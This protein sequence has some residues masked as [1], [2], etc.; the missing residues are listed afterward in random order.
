MKFKRYLVILLM[1][2]WLLSM[3]PN[4][5]FIEEG[6]PK[7]THLSVLK[8]DYDAPK[9]KHHDTEGNLLVPY[10]IAYP[11]AFHNGTVTYDL[12]TIHIKVLSSHK[13]SPS[14]AM[15]AL[16]ILS[17]SKIIGDDYA[18][19]YEAVLDDD[20]DLHDVMKEVRKLDEVLTADYNYTIKKESLSSP[21]DDVT[22][23]NEVPAIFTTL[24]IENNPRSSEQWYLS[25][26]GIPEA[27]TWM[28]DNGF[29]PGGSED[30][31]VAVID[32]GVDYNHPDLKANMWVNPNEIEDG[33]DNDGNG[34]IDD[35]HG[36]SVISDS[37]FWSGDPMDD[38]GHGTHV[39]GI[40]AA[41]NNKEGIVG[42]AHNVKIMAV[43][44][45]MSSG[46]F[47]SSAIAKGI[48]YA[49]LNGADVINM[50]FG[51]S[52]PSIPVQDALMVAYTT[53]VL[54][55][56]A[57]NSGL[58]N[59]YCFPFP[60]Y[61]PN[62]PAAL[63]Y[64][65]GVM[66]VGQ[67]NMESG[68]S[69]WD[70]K[71]YNR[72]EYEVNAPGENILS[73]LPNG[74]YVSW[75]GTSMAAPVVSGIAAL[76]RSVY[77]DRDVYPNKFIM[78]QISA[79]TNSG[80][81][82]DPNRPLH[83]VP[84]VVNAFM[85][86]T[87]LPKPD[88]SLYDYYI[89]DSETISASNNGDGIIDAGETIH[90]GIV[91]RNRWGKSEN[92]VVTIDTVTPMGQSID[93]VGIL[94]GTINFGDVG[95]YS[96][97]DF[98]SREGS[99][100]TGVE[101]PHILTIPENAPNDYIAKI[102]VNFTYE[103]ALDPNDTTIYTG[104]TEI[105]ITIRNGF[106]LPNRITED[107]VLTKENY[108][109][110]PNS[111]L[112]EEGAT[113]TVQPGTQIQFWSDDPNDAYAETAMVYLQVKGNFIVEGT[114][115]E[116]VKLFP[117]QLRDQYRVEIYQSSNGYVSIKHA[118]IINPYLSI[119]YLGYSYLTQNYVNY[120]Y[121]RYLYNG[122]VQS[123]SSYASIGANYAEYNEF[124]LI[125]GN[126]QYSKA[127]ISGTY[128]SNLFT[129]N[130]ASYSGYFE[131]NVFLTNNNL[132]YGGSTSS[133]ANV[134]LT[135]GYH[136]DQ[137]YTNQITGRT[138]IKMA[139]SYGSYSYTEF[140]RQLALNLQGDL[141]M[142]ETE[143]EKRDVLS[144]ME[145][146][147]GLVYD[148]GL[149][150]LVWLNGD[151]Y[152]PLAP[153][154]A[155]V[156][157]YAFNQNGELLASGLPYAIIE[158]PSQI[159]VNDILS[160]ADSIDLDL[161]ST[162][163]IT[164]ILDLN[165][166]TSDINSLVYVSDDETVVTVDEQG[167]ITPIQEGFA[168]IYIYSE[169]YVIEKSIRVNIVE[170]IAL[171]HI[172]VSLQNYQMNVNDTQK[173]NI[174]FNP[175]NTTEK[176]LNYISSD[177]LIA[178]VNSQGTIVAKSPGQTTIIVT[179]H[180]GT[181]SDS[182]N[183][184]VVNP[185]YS[186][187]FKNSIYI[188]SLDKVDAPEDYLPTIYPL[189]ATNQNLIWRSSNPEVAY[190]NASNEL[191]KLQ[192]G[193]TTLQ[194]KAE[195]TNI[196]EEI[197]VSVLES[198]QPSEVI[199]MFDNGN[200]YIA[201]LGSGEMIYWGSDVPSS[202]VLSTPF[203]YPIKDAAQFS[204]SYFLILLTSGELKIAYFS[205]SSSSLISS[206]WNGMSDGILASINN[207]SKIEESDNS[208][209]MLTN[210][211]YVWSF[212]Y[213]YFGQLGDGTTTSRYQNVVQVNISNVVDIKGSYNAMAYLTS[214]GDVYI[215][216][217]YH[218][219]SNP[220]KVY[221][222]V[223][224]LES[225][226]KSYIN[227]ITSSTIYAWGSE[228]HNSYNHVPNSTPFYSPS[229]QY[230]ERLM[231]ILYGELYARSYNEYGTLGL[232]TTTYVNSFQKVLGIE[233]A[234]KVFMFPYNTFVQTSDN[235]FFGFGRNNNNQLITFDNVDRYS[236]QPIFFGLTGN[237][238]Q[239]LLQNDDFYENMIYGNT[240]FTDSFDN[241]IFSIGIY[242][243]QN[244]S[245]S[246]L[247]GEFQVTIN[248]LGPSAD[249]IYFYRH[250][251]PELIVN[252]N[253]YYY[254]TIKAKADTPRDIAVSIGGKYEQFSISDA[255]QTYKIPLEF[256]YATTIDQIRIN[257]GNMTNAAT[258]TVY[259]DEI[260]LIEVTQTHDFYGN[261]F[262][263]DYNE[264][265]VPASNLALVELI[266]LENGTLLSINRKVDL[267]QLIL[268]PSNPLV[269][270]NTYVLRIPNNSVSSK[271]MVPNTE[272]YYKF[273]YRGSY[274]PSL[275]SPNEKAFFDHSKSLTQIELYFDNMTMQ[276]WDYTY[277]FDMDYIATSIDTSLYE[278]LMNIR[279]SQIKID[280]LWT[281]VNLENNELFMQLLRDALLANQDDYDVSLSF[282]V[283]ISQETYDP[284]TANIDLNLSFDHDTVL[285]Q[286]LYQE[287][288]NMDMRIIDESHPDGSDR[289][290]IDTPITIEFNQASMHTNFD[291]IKMID[292]DGMDVVTTITFIDNI[293]T[294]TPD[295][296]LIHGQTYTLIVPEGAFIDALQ[297]QNAL[298]QSSFVTYDAI[299]L[300]R[301]SVVDLQ[302]H[303]NLNQ[304][305]RLFYNYASQGINFGS[306]EVK[307]ALGNSVAITATLTNR[308]LTITPV[309]PYAENT[310]YT[311]TIPTGALID[312]MNVENEMLQYTFTTIDKIDRFYYTNEF[313]LE[314]QERLILEGKNLSNF[315]GNAI[316]NNFTETNLNYWMRFTAASGS[317]SNSY[318]MYGNY[319]GTDNQDMIDKHFIDFDVFQSLIDI[320]P[321]EVVAPP[322][323]TFPYVVDVQIY[324][325]NGE[326]HYSYGNEIVKFVV[327]FNRDM[328]TTIPL[329]FRFGSSLPYAE[330]KVEGSYLDARTW[331][332]FYE[333]RSFVESGNQYI[334]I[335]NGH[336]K[337]MPWLYL[338]WDVKRFT[339]IYDTTAAQAL[340][341]QGSTDSEG[342]HLSWLQ[343]DYE[344]I[345]GYHVYRSQTQDGTYTR[346]NSSIIPYDISTLSDHD[347]EPG[348]IYYYYFTVVL[349]DFD[350]NTG[351]FKES[352]PSGMVSIRALDTLKPNI[353]HNPVFQAYAERN[354]LIHATIVDNVTVTEAYLYF[355][356]VGETEYRKVAMT[357]LNSRYTGIIS[358][359][360]VTTLGI[361]Y[362]IEASDGFGYQYYGSSTSPITINI[363]TLVDQDAKGDVN[364]DGVI[365]VIDALMILRAINNFIVLDQDQFVRADLNG[366]GL[367]SAA[368]ALRILQYA[369]GKTTTLN[370]S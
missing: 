243:Y 45:G 217:S 284:F 319:F 163:N 118:E 17:W 215:S 271:F 35:I 2:L 161:E 320:N 318:G 31:V 94:T 293:L 333:L 8:T 279:A 347:V 56:S 259:F 167:L 291:A 262:I 249:S 26:Y 362:Y 193:V 264:A 352:D 196:V 61:Q 180:D 129:E 173:I 261:Q 265:L 82:A 24:G 213:N 197:I 337:D 115:E 294:V 149:E 130:N 165:P 113:V 245:Y 3:S 220:V 252:R 140:I 156:G 29:Q 145:G 281:S 227:I 72:V 280:G 283:E 230:N 69:N 192:S 110:I 269:V 90:L 358:A 361:E 105:F 106:I 205:A 53:S 277:R 228:L 302:T 147:V 142:F 48:E 109:I 57:G 170:K 314:T 206:T 51:G 329:D 168:N 304:E 66:S 241:Q 169:D 157:Y 36:A 21:I 84:P 32:T 307:D 148:F 350:P 322:E 50:S 159:R 342:I 369:I 355:R 195:N 67:N 324:D 312:E 233:N 226:S 120:L 254:L 190:V 108:Y 359:L 290:M 30:V 296:P 218:V 325:I 112:I 6:I 154:N 368:E 64:V 42:I 224:G 244:N 134:G 332:G 242:D 341:L 207:V 83:N 272:L 4:Q 15:K 251:N 89:Y 212:G 121:Y 122:V 55:A 201:L 44:A 151:I 309:N 178:T 234:K 60:I 268:T 11:E 79:A 175:S 231:Y 13:N 95:T 334:N 141:A 91:L 7:E 74:Q 239:L 331:V 258:G 354:I 276:Y 132:R 363:T 54:V 100:V 274:D 365:N 250:P 87:S 330:Y 99:I 210:D 73:T 287:A 80:A 19:W 240:I 237:S 335:Q 253:S 225:P 71:P 33:M 194:V 297:N 104:E 338:G 58:P 39:A 63:S 348:Q 200:Y 85:A 103:N 92:T 133:N 10:D 364:A 155:K 28:Q 345:A 22:Y 266:N 187:D 124:R 158:V 278:F 300:V 202:K 236:P 356:S 191:I 68:F 219:Y 81:I 119:D 102:N 221:S 114:L 96:T 349:T 177:E 235:R 86:I 70:C 305:F 328:E 303:I 16:G 229:W 179:N 116:P 136:I 246:F 18:I 186:L 257:L 131:N 317:S 12:H 146:H 43:K 263:F 93:E 25:R 183:I 150:A 128:V 143:D 222:D 223:I 176:Q 101:V 59:E 285:Y 20:K 198:Y 339:F 5:Q 247:N 340:S 137:I 160:S 292:K 255:Y 111:M 370:L 306:I 182:I 27:W 288:F 138:Y 323:N 343:D 77:N 97:K 209:F 326:Q 336:A 214:N 1:A 308:M 34:L 301:S 270:G 216:G 357:N 76:V 327:T 62:Y 78:G 47:T 346:I 351:M 181:L 49:Y 273:V 289:H 232:G 135:T 125:G 204:G 52:M 211:G 321:G 185:V 199:K 311:L 248:N 164:S 316:L 174:S 107:M 260:Q 203:A 162:Y 238:D 38:H 153:E 123:S 88:I 98:L 172:D 126:S 299:S 144:R 127:Q 282:E 367:L 46:F 65:I 256:K 286:Q 117:S 208:A 267:D 171:Q 184:T 295:V 9:T 75:N 344:T 189:N 366:D 313:I 152:Q 23:N 310:K 188:T 41:D 360:H 353:Y 166:V 139:Y 275:F 40:I 298:Y 315:V 37:R 14:D